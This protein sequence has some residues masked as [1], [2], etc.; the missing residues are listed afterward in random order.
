ML[1]AVTI[2]LL[3]LGLAARRRY[4][5]AQNDGSALPGRDH[6]SYF[7]FSSIAFVVYAVCLAAVLTLETPHHELPLAIN[8]ET[9]L[10]GITLTLLTTVWLVSKYPRDGGMFRTALAAWMIF[11]AALSAWGIV[12]DQQYIEEEV[13]R[14]LGHLQFCRQLIRDGKR[15][16]LESFLG[17]YFATDCRSWNREFEKTFTDAGDKK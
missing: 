9:I 14:M 12:R 4:R 11:V 10:T 1:F 15:A 13:P 2:A 7:I 3:A 16:E 17:K 5:N 8:I 6:R